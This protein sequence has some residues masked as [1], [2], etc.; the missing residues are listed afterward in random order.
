MTNKESVGTAMAESNE[1]KKN[2]YEEYDK[3]KY[4]HGIG[5]KIR[6]CSKSYF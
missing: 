1:M 4:T 6:G 2:E 3:G 5:I